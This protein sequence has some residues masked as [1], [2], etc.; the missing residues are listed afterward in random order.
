M[1]RRRKTS[2]PAIAGGCVCALFLAACGRPAADGP[3]AAARGS[4]A[5]LDQHL[6]MMEA[7]SESMEKARGADEVA[8]ALDRYAGDLEGLAPAYRT[9]KEDYP[10]WDFIGRFPEELADYE[11]RYAE[12]AMRIMRA[13]GKALQFEGHPEVDRAQSRLLRVS[14]SME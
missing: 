1:S 5:V 14:Q 3:P 4:R 7:F 2:W 10:D 13:M 6:R 11:V 12:T 8:A 9:L